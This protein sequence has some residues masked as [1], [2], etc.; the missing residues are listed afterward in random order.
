MDLD[1]RTEFR[2]KVI[3]KINKIMPELFEIYRDDG[4][5]LNEALD[6]LQAEAMKGYDRFIQQNGEENR[7]GEA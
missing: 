7:S 3:E 4:K 6:Y 2:D 5:G 1:K